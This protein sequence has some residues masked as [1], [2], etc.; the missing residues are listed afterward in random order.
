M[1]I[2]DTLQ[3][4]RDYVADEPHEPARYTPDQLA[5]LSPT[6]KAHTTRSGSR[7]STATSSCPRR[8]RRDRP[9]RPPARRLARVE[10]VHRPAR[11]RRVR[12]VHARQ[13]HR[14]HVG[15]EEARAT[16]AGKDRP[17]PTTRRSRPSSTSPHP[18]GTTP[19]G[20]M[21][22]FCHWLGL[23]MHRTSTAQELTEQVIPVL[24]TLGTT[25]VLRR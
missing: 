17:R 20:M 19:K 16:D 23:P 3:A 22:A 5:A 8:H 25:M 18:P 7:S 14:H 21:A 24:R 9:E 13:V 11:T 4:W 12:P 10:E 15:R 1:A 2:P 6:D